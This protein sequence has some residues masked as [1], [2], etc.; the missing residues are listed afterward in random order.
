MKINLL[1]LL[2]ILSIVFA[3]SCS[4]DDPEVVNE[5]ELITTLVY[6]L[7]PTS[8]GETVIMRFEDKDGDGGNAPIVTNGTLS[9]NTTYNGTISVLDESTDDVEDIT[10]EV[11][12]EGA[13]H[14]FFFQATVA[15]LDVQYSDTDENGD[16]IG[17]TN[18]LATQGA[19]SGNLTITLRHEPNK[20]A[21]GV[22]TGDLTNAGGETDIEV[23]FAVD[24]M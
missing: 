19:G 20:A 15:G 4:K 9:A 17:I 8:G 10:V 2:A 24:V 3:T 13:E 23:T 16:P 22:S 6:T 1:S 14:Q 18:T 21:S 7:T 11:R 5:E 12:E